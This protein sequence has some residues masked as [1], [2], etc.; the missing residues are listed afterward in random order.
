MI[1]ENLIKVI[2]VQEN[3]QDLSKKVELIESIASANTRIS[4]LPRIHHKSFT[5]IS[6]SYTS[7]LV[8]FIDQTSQL[9]EAGDMAA[10]ELVDLSYLQ[11]TLRLF[12]KLEESM[13]AKIAHIKRTLPQLAFYPDEQILHILLKESLMERV[14]SLLS[15]IYPNFVSIGVINNAGEPLKM[16]DIQF[17]DGF[18]KLE[19]P[20]IIPENLGNLL[21]IFQALISQWLKG[22]VS[23]ALDKGYL[24]VNKDTPEQIYRLFYDIEFTKN[25]IG[26]NIFILEFF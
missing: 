17:K 21:D 9:A 10:L 23:D 13:N 8:K 4:C 20:V 22:I 16:T 2:E 25:L 6:L 26:R 7:A 14:M 19:M 24:D 1:P 12:Q 5:E 18:Y 15:T 11:Y 3:S